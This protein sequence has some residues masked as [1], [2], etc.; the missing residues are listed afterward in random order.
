MQTFVT[1]RLFQTGGVW[2]LV[3]MWKELLLVGLF[4]FLSWVLW[5]RRIREA[6]RKTLPIKNFVLAFCITLGLAFL[7]S[8]FVN[9]S[10]LSITVMSLRYSMMGFFIFIVFFVLSYLFFGARE[11]QITKRYTNGIK[12][13]LVCSLIRWGI[14]WLTPNLM[15]FVGYDQNNYE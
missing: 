1:Y 14:I 8:I 7:I 5:K 10:G 3:W 12:T 6:R 15:R 2:N 4:G 9:H 13:L 11:I